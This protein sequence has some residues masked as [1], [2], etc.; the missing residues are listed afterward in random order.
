MKVACHPAPEGDSSMVYPVAEDNPLIPINFEWPTL[1]LLI[2][3][4]Y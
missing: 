4:K 1:V 3:A 2:Y